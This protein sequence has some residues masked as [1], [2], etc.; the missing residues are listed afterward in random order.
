MKGKFIVFEG[1]EGAG[2]TTQMR[3]LL[4]F[5]QQK[6]LP[7][8]SV[9]ATR[10]PGGTKLGKELRCLLLET[11]SVELVSN[12][13]ELLMYAA[14]RAQHVEAFLLPELAKGSI[15]LCDR[16]TDSTVA[17]Q[18]YGRGLNL[19]LIKQLNE[20]ATGG[21]QSDLTLWLDINVED[22]LS[23]VM[24]R[25][26][27]D[28]MEQ[29]DLEFHRRVQQGFAELAEENRDRIFRIDASRPEDEVAESIQSIVAS[30]LE[31]WR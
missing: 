15:V 5:I 31:A 11:E 25:G 14:D 9:V 7:Q 20:I 30:K 17:Y 13:A 28:R 10:E 19:N 29:A 12:R 26:K 1:V 23:R 24:A 16:F 3:H 2:K 4:H 18:G 6:Q 8:T 21:L 22:G 27:R